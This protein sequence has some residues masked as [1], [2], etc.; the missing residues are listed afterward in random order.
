MSK[1]P[2]ERL[3]AHSSEVMLGPNPIV[4]FRGR[5]VAREAFR[6]LKLAA[7]QPRLTA[8]TAVS[9]GRELAQ[10]LRDRSELAPAPK[11]RRFSDVAWKDDPRYRRWLQSWLAL[12]Q[13]VGEWLEAQQLPAHSH[14]RLQF[15]ASL[16]TDAVAPSNFPWQPEAVKR[17][18]E[19]GG[20]SAVDG[21]KNLWRDLRDNRGLPAQVDK[22]RFRIGENLA[23]TPGSVVLRT[24]LMELIQYRPT[25]EQVHELPVLIVPPQ[26]NKYYVF[27]ITPEKS[28]VKALLE[29]GLQVFV[30]SWRN[31][32]AEH[33]DWGLAEYA[34]AI[35]TAVSAICNLG[36]VQRVNLV[37]ACAGGMT[38]ASYVAARAAAGDARVNSLT[39]MVNVLDI[40]AVGDTPMGLFATPRA[41]AAAK[42]YSQAKGVL[43]GKDMA[44][45]FAWL[46]PNDLI[47][48]YWVNNVLLG[49]TPPAF[50]V[51]YWNNDSTRLP[52]RLHGEFMDIYNDNALTRPGKLRLHGVPVDLGRVKCDSYLLSGTT[53][54]IT[55]WKACYRSTQLFGGNKT[56]VLSSSGH[57]QS[58]LN[59]P[60]NKK[61]AFWTGGNTG[62]D[63]ETWQAGAERHDGSWWP[64]W[65]AWLKQRS[66][67]MQA[68][69]AQEGSADYPVLA[70]APGQYVLG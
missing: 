58:I 19:T 42:R 52:A 25:T 49:N 31:P 47:W 21:L 5:D 29:Q 65:H 53:D 23:S 10:V 26:I 66:G 40:S 13:T 59:P 67:A 33:R 69:P 44:T 48:N 22:T 24:E 11:D 6:V 63:A 64:H 27:D 35:D 9:F 60:G 38:L 17:F 37:G 15:M 20:H 43:D 28:V 62:P 45:A 1:T 57:I 51:L 7:A 54:H 55:P 18:R 2:Q 14:A 8:K 12:E 36:A 39:L 4:G 56:F 32:G 50:D 70:A 41:I 34:A 30:I 61:A 3:A 46:R 16:V 68:A